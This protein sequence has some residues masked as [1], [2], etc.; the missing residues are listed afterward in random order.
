MMFQYALVQ[1]IK[2]A[3]DAQDADLLGKYNIKHQLQK[4][5]LGISYKLVDLNDENANL[6]GKFIKDHDQFQKEISTIVRL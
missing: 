5:P 4:W 2:E 3:I 6:Q 1:K